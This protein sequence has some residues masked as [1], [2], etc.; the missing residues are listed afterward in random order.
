MY[1]PDFVFAITAAVVADRYI[2]KS[3]DFE[4]IAYKFS[5]FLNASFELENAETLKSAAEAFMYTMAEADIEN[6]DKMLL[7]Y[8]HNKFILKPNGKIRNWAPIF[9]NPIQGVKTKNY[10]PGTINRDFKAF[11]YRTKQSGEYTCPSGWSLS[12][13]TLNKFLKDMGSL[14]VSAFDIINIK[15]SD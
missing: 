15:Q 7:N 5:S 3:L 2:T 12:S 13:Q 4:T 11:V 14:E 9:G 6:A 8:Q 10:N 1:A